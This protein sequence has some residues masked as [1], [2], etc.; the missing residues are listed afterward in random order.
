MNYKQS[1]IV[2][3]KAQNLQNPCNFEN[4]TMTTSLQNSFIQTQAAH[5]QNNSTKPKHII[6]VQFSFAMVYLLLC[7]RKGQRTRPHGHGPV[8]LKRSSLTKRFKRHCIDFDMCKCSMSG[9]SILKIQHF[10]HNPCQQIIFFQGKGRRRLQIRLYRRYNISSKTQRI[11]SFLGFHRSLLFEYLP[12]FSFLLPL[13]ATI[14][15]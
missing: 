10:S 9:L 2:S 7:Q 11:Y 15:V 3:S 13:Q 8:V 12:R 4:N 5:T 1:I 6:V 14:K